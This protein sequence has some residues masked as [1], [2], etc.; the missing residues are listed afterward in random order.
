MYICM[1]FAFKPW[2]QSK[3]NIGIRYQCKNMRLKTNRKKKHFTFDIFLRIERKSFFFV[4]GF[5]G[6]LQNKNKEYECYS[7][8]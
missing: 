2:I 3:G 4:T 1:K 7:C 5:N 6:M 8:F